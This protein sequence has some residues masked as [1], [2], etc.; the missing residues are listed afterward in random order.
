MIAP[1]AAIMPHI[2]FTEKTD[3]RVSDFAG[4]GRSGCDRGLGGTLMSADIIQPIP[5]PRY[6]S[7]QTDFPTIAFRSAVR[8]LAKER[9]EPAPRDDTKTDKRESKMSKAKALTSV[10]SLARSHTRTAITVLAK[11][12]RSE[13][14]TPAARVSAAN[15]LLDRGWG[16]ATQ[17]LG[18]G[19][20]GTLGIIHRIERIIVHPQNSDS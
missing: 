7:E 14:A 20:D 17:P 15:A 16:K 8:D 19:D 18:S 2:S 4:A 13:D 10:R 5:R 12:M 6:A 9:A 3:D 1:H 11:I